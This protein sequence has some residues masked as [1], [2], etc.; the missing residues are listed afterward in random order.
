M[1]LNSM[2]RI[3]TAQE[4]TPGTTVTLDDDA[5][6]HVRDVLRC[7]AGTTLALFNGD[8]C[9]YTAELTIVGGGAVTASVIARQPRTHESPLAITLVQAISR[10]ERM[11]YTVQKAVE[12]GVTAIAPVM[13]RR[14]VVR[15]DGARELKR[16]AH[17][18]GIVR[19]AAEQSGRSVLPEV[20]AI[21][22]L[23]QW[24]TARPSGACLSLEP[25][26]E[27]NLA[28]IPDPGDALA[29]VAGPEGGFE[30]E[31]VALMRAH[32]VSGVRLGPRILRTETAA[33][34]A[35]VVLQ[36]RFGDLA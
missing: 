25:G 10:G 29:I 1:P 31:E 15:L 24:L 34:C 21:V 23:A 17:W 20:H 18:R 26:A 11:D 22:S 5:A 3:Y 35:L 6:H 7:T 8:G 28:Q 2:T 14:S 30:P 27:R 9:D 19:H 36:T 12:L 4:L 32:G 33:L 16:L 13:S